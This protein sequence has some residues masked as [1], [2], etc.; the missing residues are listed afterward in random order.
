M[1][2][3]TEIEAKP[4]I[5]RPVRGKK[6]SFQTTLFIKVYRKEDK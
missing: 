3:P 6:L 2:F 4:G 1:R 5:A